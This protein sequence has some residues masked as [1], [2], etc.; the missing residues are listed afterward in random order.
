MENRKHH[1]IRLLQNRQ[2]PTYQLYAEM[3]N[4]KTAL[5]DS[6]RLA[7]LTTMEWLRQRLQDSI[8]PELDQPDPSRFRDV[9]DE[10][11]KS[12][13]MSRG[14]VIDIVSLPGQGLWALQ[15]TEPDLGSDPGCPDQERQPVPGRV[16][17]TN[18][19]FLISG[20]TLECAFQSVISDPEFTAEQADVYRIT[21]AQWL[22][23]NPSFDLRQITVLGSA[24]EQI[25][26]VSQIKNLIATQKHE[27]NHRS[28]RRI[29]CPSSIHP[30]KAGVANAATHGGAKG[31]HCA[32]R[33]S[34]K[35][36]LG[37]SRSE[38]RTANANH[39]ESRARGRWAKLYAL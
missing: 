17:V 13:H 28:M 37:F 5:R 14:F 38:G 33:R 32:F 39:S 9:S 15:I 24:A 25:R 16:F 7:A 19:G 2:Y 27:K 26:T 35:G 11:L 36:W 30:R 4:K 29:I 3:A 18:V 23:V 22:M 6:L 34:P 31:S 12:F 21:P 1:V 8:P 10:C 20:R